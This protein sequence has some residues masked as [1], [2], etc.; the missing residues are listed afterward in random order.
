MRSRSKDERDDTF[1]GNVVEKE[2]SC[3]LK[4]TDEFGLLVAGQLIEDVIAPFGP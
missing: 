1:W 4:F 3:E 2:F